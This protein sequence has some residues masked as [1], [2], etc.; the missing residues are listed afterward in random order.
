MTT[1]SKS[2]T[3]TMN[4]KKELARNATENGKFDP[5]EVK[6]EQ[7]TEAE[8]QAK[9]E[10]QAQPQKEPVE[11]EPVKTVD[12]VFTA[13]QRR[14]SLKQLNQLDAKLTWLQNKQD[15]LNTFEISN[16]GTKESIVLSNASGFRFEV[17][18]TQIIHE[19]LE[20]LRNQVETKISETQKDIATFNF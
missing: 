5:R 15:E 6:T 10:P 2:H 9:A 17:T 8:A 3:A 13:E 7:K 1:K 20:L 16:E 18:N 19:V 12:A 11:V 4:A 14:R